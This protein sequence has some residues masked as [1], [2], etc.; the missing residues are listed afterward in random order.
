MCIQS[1]NSELEL[2][3]LPTKFSYAFKKIKCYYKIYKIYND[4]SD[5]KIIKT[6][7][8]PQNIVIFASVISLFVCL[9]VL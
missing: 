8:T 6:Y 3:P 2:V 5:N 4:K 1:V 7:V 9:Y